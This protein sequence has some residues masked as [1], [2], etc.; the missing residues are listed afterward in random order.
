MRIS[1]NFILGAGF[2]RCKSIF[3][4]ASLG[5]ETYRN[6][7]SPSISALE[8][9]LPGHISAYLKLFQNSLFLEKFREKI[10]SEKKYCQK[11]LEIYLVSRSLI[12]NQRPSFFGL[13]ILCKISILNCFKQIIVKIII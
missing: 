10:I 5:A 12:T 13:M 1:F 8:L 6:T 9:K 4:A 11:Y 3:F 7:F 2:I